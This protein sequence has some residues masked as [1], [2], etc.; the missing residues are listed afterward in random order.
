[1]AQTPPK[2]IYL[3]YGT[4]NLLRRRARGELVRRLLGDGDADLNVSVFDAEADLSDVLDT[5]RT[6]PFLSPRRVVVVEQADTFLA[7]HVEALQRYLLDPAPTGSLVLVV[8]SLPDRSPA[9]RKA[10][11][12]LVRAGEA[13]DCSPDRLDPVRWAIDSANRRGKRLAREAA[14]LLVE[15]VGADLARLDSE[16]EK[17]SL[18]VG[19]RG[20]ILPED[21]GALVADT[22]GAA[23]YALTNAIGRGRPEAALKALH[24]MLLR[25]GDEV[26]LLGLIGWHLRSSLSGGNRV[27][28]PPER[29]EGD[30]RR[31]LAA[32]LALKSGASPL[33]TMQTLVIGLCL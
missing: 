19:S 18:F 31:V 22:A 14:R 16:I 1:V 15:C 25:R 6:V 4:D 33:A 8:D 32:D 30:F 23:R 2:P 5:L 3:L 12:S 7:A 17:L 10:V 24:R 28:S 9:V 29:V 21:V 26:R 13:I 11:E 20:E 27:P